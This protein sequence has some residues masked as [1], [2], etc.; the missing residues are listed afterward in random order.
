MSRDGWWLKVGRV[1]VP[2][3]SS[4]QKYRSKA[5]GLFPP[6]L[7]NGHHIEGEHGVLHS[8]SASSRQLGSIVEIYVYG[9]RL[10]LAIS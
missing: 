2:D 10:F 7:E 9:D 3:N 6:E 4:P 8:V 1:R 5:T